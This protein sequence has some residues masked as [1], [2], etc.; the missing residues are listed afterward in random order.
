[1]RL[2]PIGGAVGAALGVLAALIAIEALSM[3]AFE[4]GAGRA[5]LGVA[6]ALGLGASQGA[7]WS[8]WGSRP[9][10]TR[11]VWIGAVCAGFVALVLTRCWST[12]LDLSVFGAGPA[13]RLA[14]VALPLSQAI[15]GV[16]LGSAA[17]VR[18]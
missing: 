2:E 15:A 1:M 5:L 11:L 17:T 4:P 3:P 12:W 10:R 14:L 9:H 16:T 6:V 8:C 18:G 13:G 7:A